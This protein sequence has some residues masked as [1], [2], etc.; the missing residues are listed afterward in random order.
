M[1]VAQSAN[2]VIEETKRLPESKSEPLLFE[3]WAATIRLAAIKAGKSEDDRI[4][5][6]D[7]DGKAYVVDPDALD[8]RDAYDRAMSGI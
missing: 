7:E 2:E 4:F 1:N 5:I 6:L 3:I 8:V